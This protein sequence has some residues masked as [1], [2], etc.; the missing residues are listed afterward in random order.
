M[1]V[2]VADTGHLPIQNLTILGSIMKKS[3]TLSI[4]FLLF[5]TVNNLFAADQLKIAYVNLNKAINMSNE[6]KRSKKFLE[7]QARQTR[8]DIQKKEQALRQKEKELQDM[9]MLSSEAKSKKEL[10]ISQM[11]LELRKEIDQ[12][13]KDFR[14]DEVRH[15]GKIF[16]DLKVI[17][18]NFAKKRNYDLVLEYNLKQTLLFSKYTIVDITDEIT[19]AYNK[20]QTIK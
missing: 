3:L 7:V 19:E 17:I 12:A 10:E 16:A 13:Q 9:L 4:S 8:S 20:Q 11:K 6:G 2:K 5:F 14:A 1:F 15:T 18:S